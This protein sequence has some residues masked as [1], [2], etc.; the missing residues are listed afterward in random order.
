M[1]KIYKN[2]LV[3]IIAIATTG[4]S[5][6]QAWGNFANTTSGSLDGVAF[7]FSISEEVT[8]SKSGTNFEGADEGNAFYSA[9]GSWYSSAIK[10]KNLQEDH[11][12]TITFESPIENLNFYVKDFRGSTLKFDQEF[13]LLSNTSLTAIDATTLSTNLPSSGIIQFNDPITTLTMTVISG[14]T[15][16][17]SR[18]IAFSNLET[19]GETDPPKTPE[20]VELPYYEAFDYA[21]GDRL[22]T[23]GTVSGLG[24]W[25]AGA[26]GASTDPAIITSPTWATPT[27]LPAA[28]GEALTFT[29]G[30]DNPYISI[31]SQDVASTTLYTS[32][33]FKV[34]SQAL[35]TDAA[36]N[37]FFLAY[38]GTTWVGTVFIQRVS[39]TEFQL[40]IGESTSR[41]NAVYTTD[42]YNVN[43][44][45]FL[46]S[47]Y[48]TGNNV[49]ADAVAKLWV[50]PVVSATEPVATIT[51]TEAIAPIADI[52]RVYFVQAGGTDAVVDKTPTVI[53][54]ELRVANT[55]ADVVSTIATLGVNDE[56]TKTNKLKLFPNP[57][58]DFIQVS[59]LTATANYSIYNILG[60]E[61]RSGSVSENNKIEVANLINGLYFLK[62]ESGNTIKFVKK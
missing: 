37:P 53:I 51:S 40:G 12:F 48:T 43:D 56:Y 15:S 29:G 58:S 17:S 23:E 10:I 60:A 24:E 2:F 14:S 7:T 20:T 18:Y 36:T 26:D 1:R 5:H 31:T 4:L 45:L 55:W 22:I 54:D 35:T 8:P 19:T 52:N 11:T 50:N 46:V 57:S 25:Q 33:M 42:T 32:L 59:G 62:L 6:A 39:D 44:E 3:A 30:G 34:T 47:S 27:G 13:T 49:T 16:T 38:F 21:V 61:V 41:D 9:P 28:T